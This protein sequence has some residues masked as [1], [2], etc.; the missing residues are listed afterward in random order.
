M[1]SLLILSFSLLFLS[2]RSNVE[3]EFHLQGR[4]MGTTF[5]IKYIGNDN[6]PSSDVLLKEVNLQLKAIN[7]QMSTYQADSEIS[8]FNQMARLNWV[9]ISASFFSVLE[10][11][12]KLAKETEGIF[13]PTIG[14]LVNLWGFGPNGERKVPSQ[15]DI[16]TVKLKV[17]FVH[18]AIK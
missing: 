1:K 12:L 15:K 6:L 3:K 13:D 5:S 16:E 17:G 7:A 18:K 14:P 8:F 11:S 4:T 9:P 2:C 10:Y